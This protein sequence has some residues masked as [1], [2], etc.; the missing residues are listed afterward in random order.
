DRNRHRRHRARSGRG[1]RRGRGPALPPPRA[2]EGRR[3]PARCRDGRAGGPDRS[4]RACRK[5]LAKGAG[6]M[7]AE[8][9][10]RLELEPYLQFTRA[11]WSQLRAD[12]PMTLDAG[13]IKRLRTLNDPISLG[14]AEEVY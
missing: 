14:E 10:G 13:D 7:M 12:E 8:R 11:E 1:R 2:P 4:V 6:A 3:C 5:G 9:S